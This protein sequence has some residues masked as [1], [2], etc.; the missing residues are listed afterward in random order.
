MHVELLGDM[1]SPLKPLNFLS[2][3]KMYM[4]ACL[5]EKKTLITPRPLINT[6]ICVKS[7]DGKPPFVI[8]TCVVTL[9]SCAEARTDMH[10]GTEGSNT[11]PC[12]FPFSPAQSFSTAL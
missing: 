5:E 8:L 11:L 4:A 3:A 1:F 12:F 10:I 6:A 9:P 2:D 7:M